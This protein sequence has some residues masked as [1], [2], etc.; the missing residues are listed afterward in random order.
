[1]IPGAIEEVDTAAKLLGFT[2]QP[3]TY[4]GLITTVALH[5]S[6]VNLMFSKGAELAER[7]GGELLDGTGKRARHVKLRDLRQLEDARIRDLLAAAAELTPRP[8]AGGG[9]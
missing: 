9:Q 5:R 4:K 3:G 8:G 2:F 1:M 6:H 7:D